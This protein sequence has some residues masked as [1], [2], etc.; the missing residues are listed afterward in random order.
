MFGGGDNRKTLPGYVD[1]LLMVFD[2]SQRIGITVALSVLVTLSI[3]G[4]VATL[5]TN[6]RR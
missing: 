6:I 3:V 1:Y 5:I 2:D 4:N